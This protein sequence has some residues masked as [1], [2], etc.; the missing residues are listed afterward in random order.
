MHPYNFL[1]FNINLLKVGDGKKLLVNELL[2]IKMFGVFNGRQCIKK[3]RGS[4]DTR[5]GFLKDRP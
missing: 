4:K 1:L 2:T 3:A 5:A